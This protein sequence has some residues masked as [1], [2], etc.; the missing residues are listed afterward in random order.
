ML[1]TVNMVTKVL[2]TNPPAAAFRLGPHDSTP[3]DEALQRESPLR[4]SPAD[5]VH[6][7]G[8]VAV[9]VVTIGKVLMRVGDRLMGVGMPV[10]DAS[11]NR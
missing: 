11:R 8:G 5:P 9:P 2:A 1:F 7:H 4:A 10:S 6:S 3:K